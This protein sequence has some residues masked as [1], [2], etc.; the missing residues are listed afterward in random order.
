MAKGQDTKLDWRE[1]RK[2]RAWDLHQQGWKQLMQMHE[3]SI[4]DHE[5]VR[6]LKHLV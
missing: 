2:F 1:E 6:F 3:H 5:C 4:S